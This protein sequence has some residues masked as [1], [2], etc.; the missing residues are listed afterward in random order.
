MGKK[1]GMHGRAWEVR[2]FTCGVEAGTWHLGG[3]ASPSP[4]PFPST[5]TTPIP[6]S[7]HHCSHRTMSACLTPWKQEEEASL[8]EDNCSPK[9]R[10][11]G[12]EEL[13]CTWII[14]KLLSHKPTLPGHRANSSFCQRSGSCSSHWWVGEAT[15]QPFQGAS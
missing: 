15:V 11:F 9:L 4:E 2:P 12:R 5:P 13:Y 8:G 10:F 3:A 14:N 1:L 6:L 7:C